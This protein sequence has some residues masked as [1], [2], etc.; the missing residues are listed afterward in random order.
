M[1]VNALDV[2]RER[3]MGEKR[4]VFSQFEILLSGF[5]IRI[6]KLS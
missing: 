1:V 4:L 5:L 6:S 3:A 2:L